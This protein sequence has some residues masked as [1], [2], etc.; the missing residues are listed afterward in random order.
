MIH[1]YYYTYNILCILYMT[2]QTS[3]EVK[4]DEVKQDGFFSIFNNLST[5]LNT[6][7]KELSKESKQYFKNTTNKAES[8]VVPQPTPNNNSTSNIDIAG[9]TKGSQQKIDDQD[10]IDAEVKQDEEKVQELP[11]N[12]EISIFQEKYPNIDKN[13]HDLYLKYNKT[14]FNFEDTIHSINN[15]LSLMLEVNNIQEKNELR[16][17]IEH[18]LLEIIIKKKQGISIDDPQIEIT[19][20]KNKFDNFENTIKDN[21]EKNKIRKIKLAVLPSLTNDYFE[22]DDNNDIPNPKKLQQLSYDLADTVYLKED[23]AMSWEN[24]IKKNIDTIHHLIP[25][26]LSE[27]KNKEKT[28]ELN[29]DKQKRENDKILKFIQDRKNNKN[30]PIKLYIGKEEKEDPDIHFNPFYIT[31][32]NTSINNEIERL[33][34]QYDEIS[35]FMDSSFYLKGFENEPDLHFLDLKE[36]SKLAYNY[37]M[38]K[39]DCINNAIHFLKDYPGI[40]YNEKTEEIMYNNKIPELSEYDIDEIIKNFKTKIPDFWNDELNKNIKDS[41]IE[42]YEKFHDLFLND[43]NIIASY[44]ASVQSISSVDILLQSSNATPVIQAAI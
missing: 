17:M 8:K 7:I 21:D 22:K 19:N 24:F 23:N 4:Q 13:M 40:E 42:F 35:Y 39:Y 14:H 37:K 38:F 28:K 6:E 34:N 32:L 18:Y 15:D 29:L 36:I 2:D 27:P 43:A 5:Q 9:A 44:K 16:R 11:I 25:S 3:N 33:R 31:K 30:N 1:G 20:T 10:K 26:E 41:D 12:K